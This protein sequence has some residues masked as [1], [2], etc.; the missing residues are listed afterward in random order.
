ML[1]IGFLFL[2]FVFWFLFSSLIVLLSSLGL[3]LP[4]IFV[5]RV[6][7]VACKHLTTIFTKKGDLMCTC[8]MYLVLYIE[9]YLQPP[10]P[11]VHKFLSSRCPTLFGETCRS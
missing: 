7:D 10:S 11:Y 4:S 1:G 8:D 2:F 3:H 6:E 9:Y 5:N